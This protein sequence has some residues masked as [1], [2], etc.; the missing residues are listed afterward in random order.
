M[1]PQRDWTKFFLDASLHV[2]TMSTCL[3]RHTGAVIVQHRHVI[4]TGFNG[5]MPAALH[6]NDG[7]CARCGADVVVPGADLGSCTCVH[8]EANAI[9]QCARFGSST[10]GTTMYCTTK[11]CLDCIKLIAVSGIVRVVYDEDYPASY[12]APPTVDLVQ[13]ARPSALLEKYR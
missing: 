6:C 13:H 3:T 7:G 5:N 4:S 11:P 12:D 1:P 2:A 8:A 10:N 9:A